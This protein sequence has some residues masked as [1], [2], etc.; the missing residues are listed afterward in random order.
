ME[1]KSNIK[2]GGST[3]P[4]DIL[5]AAL[6]AKV[7]ATGLTP[8]KEYRITDF[9]TSYTIPNTTTFFTA[10]V[11]PLIVKAANV[12]T[13]YAEAR[14]NTYPQ[15][16]IYYELVCTHKWA[17]V[18]I[19][20]DR[21]WIYYREDTLQSNKLD[22]DFRSV[23]WRRWN[24]QTDGLGTWSE[25]TDNTFPFQ[26]FLTFQQYAQTDGNTFNV[27]GKYGSV[28]NPQIV[29]SNY[30]NVFFGY[31]R[32]NYSR[33]LFYNNTFL[34]G[35]H[36]N[37]Y[38]I[39]F[40]NNILGDEFIYNR[41]LDS[42]QS[43]STSNSFNN[44][45]VGMDFT[46]FSFPNE[47][48]VDSFIGGG[49]AGSG[50]DHPPIKIWQGS[51]TPAP[52]PGSIEC[53][54]VFYGTDRAGVRKTF[55]FLESPLFTG[56]I[57]TGGYTV[58]TLPAGEL[59]D[60][61]YVTDAVAPSSL[62]ALTGG[63]TVVVPVLKNATAWV[64]NGG[65]A[66]TPNTSDIFADFVVS[67]LLSPTSAD[68][69]STLSAG[70]AYVIGLRVVVP[71]T[72]FTYTAS[73]DTYVDLSSSGVLTYIAVALGAAAP[74]L[75][76]A[77][78]RLQK[79]VTN[80]TAVTA[81]TRLASLLLTLAK[82]LGP[83]TV[84]TLKTDLQL[85]SVENTA[86]STWAGSTNI[87]TLGAVTATSATTP[88]IIGGTAVGSKITYK[89]T[90]GVGT[91]TGIAHQFVGG[92]NGATVLATMLN[93]G[94]GGWGTANPISAFNVNQVAG[95]TKGI[96]ITGDEVYASGN[97]TADKGVRIAVGVNRSVN[98]Q[99]WIGDADAYGSST[100]GLFRYQTG[101]ALPSI[102]AVTGNGL[103]R[104]NL[105]LA[106]AT[107]NVII[108]GNDSSIVQPVSKLSVMGNLSVGFDYPTN[109]APTNGAIIE[110]NVGFGL[111]SPT[112]VTHLKAGTAAAGTA[113]QKFTSG[114]LL[115]APEPGAVEFLTDAWYATITTGSARKQ[116]A[117][118]G[119]TVAPS[120]ITVGASPFV[121]QNATGYTAEV[122]CSG[123]TVTEIAISRDGTTYYP[124][125]LTSGAPVLGPGDRVKVTYSAAPTM[126]SLTL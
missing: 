18:L 52:I 2:G 32:G 28:G 92:T 20:A 91:P 37:D 42:F 55:A 10:A 7:G 33:G 117:F 101:S 93:N 114:P 118:T 83:A 67:G 27:A 61:A 113:P 110:G 108:G 5:Y 85:D 53:P 66:L 78:L 90:T 87:T 38:G 125:G 54:D 82:S 97:G 21:G 84:D 60:Q 74:A 111:T 107:S 46:G 22:Y 59:G 9:R 12:N 94:N 45:T 16:I 49:G 15:D 71:D 24:S 51:L 100:L 109:A 44:N 121:Y 104:L 65:T 96:I 64:A 122:I 40:A 120:A 62:A 4:E 81:V 56:P 35:T 1:V 58:A 3:T 115:T 98:R 34:A 41:I 72:P 6:V 50:S 106:S 75:T 63:G 86:L 23:K 39:R 8:E 116:L 11:E 80:A 25:L 17:S 88:L 124:T 89:S 43:C 73:S 105:A 47:I 57:R 31:C 29:G 99:L 76:A 30:N 13:L 103:T 26:D 79:V 112:A 69:T 19:T 36:H 14:S 126:T 123:G 70:A 95:T 77:S 119:Y 68:L 102:D 48:I